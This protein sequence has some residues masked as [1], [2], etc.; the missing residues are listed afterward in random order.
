MINR[1]RS[2][3]AGKLDPPVPGSFLRAATQSPQLIS[4]ALVLIILVV[5]WS[6]R[7]HGFVNLDDQVYVTENPHVVRGITWPNVVWAFTNLEAGFWHPL[8]WLSIMLDCQL[9]GLRP[10]GHHLSSLLMHAANTVLLFLLFR[11]M[12]GA[13][14]RSA[15]VAALFA[16][17]PLHVETVAWAADRKDVLSAFFALLML[18]AYVR[19][20]Q[21]CSVQNTKLKGQ[22]SEKVFSIQYS[23]FSRGRS[24][25]YFAALAFFACAVMSKTMVVTLP[26]IL[27]LLDF[28]P[29]RRFEPNTGYW[30]LKG[31]RPLFLEKMPFLLISLLAGLLTVHAER[32]VGALPG[33]SRVPIQFR[34]A[35]A[36][37]SCLRYLTQTIWPADL[38]VFYPYPATFSP[39]SVAGAALFLLVLSAIALRLYRTKPYLAVWWFWYLLL[40]LP[41]IGLIQVGGHAHAD[42]YTY[43][44][45]IGVFALLS[46]GVHDL[47]KHWRGSALVLSI[48]A[49]VVL[50]ACTTLTRQQLAFWRDSGTLFGHA[51]RVTKDNYIAYY[52]LGLYVS[53]E[54]KSDEA[55]RNYRLALQANPAYAEAYNNL[56]LELAMKGNLSEAMNHFREAIRFNPQLA[57]AHSNLGMALASEG[58]ASEAI[59]EYQESLRLK[60]DEA[61]VH[62]NLAN[63][64]DEQGQPA[65]AIRHYQEALR[66]DPG[67]PE[68]HLN[69][70]MTLAAQGNREQAIAHY[71]EALRLKP[72][73][74]QAKQELRK[75][76]TRASQP[77]P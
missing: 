47:T 73:Y 50:S 40:L 70:G 15:F 49:G 68:I 30:K 7:N 28:W 37:L 61:R 75:L 36:V 57:S 56:G 12:T 19:Y 58:K 46:W 74:A 38:A 24:V 33:A 62:S 67:S 72:D 2:S 16:L 3:I 53:G 63:V 35:N 43:V 77:N 71:A 26:L 31:L 39:G 51:I 4:F 21:T 65:D 11:R 64:L 5:F 69:L 13:T 22:N 8:T 23:V 14:W 9:Y 34:M 55:M 6:A 25:W 18:W 44:P 59:R 45:L 76:A 17:H 42:R 52:C 54:G 41:V 60:P 32:G 27:L 1:E 29:L 66:F 10:G 20:A 48:A